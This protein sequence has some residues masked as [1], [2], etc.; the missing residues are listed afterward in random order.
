MNRSRRSSKEPLTTAPT[1][2]G[3][4]QLFYLGA[5]RRLTGQ[6]AL[7]AIS[8]SH[9]DQTATA[10]LDLHPRSRSPCRICT[11]TPSTGSVD[12]AVS[13]RLSGS[14]RGGGCGFLGWNATFTVKP[15]QYEVRGEPR[16]AENR[17]TALG[18][19][20]CRAER[21]SG[22][23]QASRLSIS[24]PEPDQRTWETLT[25]LQ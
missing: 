9:H 10:D 7:V 19:L 11:P 8:F 24:T 1:P 6:R 17:H 14:V 23:Q 25:S 16:I 15:R 4:R 18:S 3:H 2:A 13:S 5:P 22:P 20:R 21:Q 12:R